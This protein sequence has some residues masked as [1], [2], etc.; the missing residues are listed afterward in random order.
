[1]MVIDADTGNVGIGDSSPAS[2]LTVGNNDLFQV[3]TSGQVIAGI[4]QGTAINDT[5]ISSSSNWNTAY[6]WGDHASEG[7]LTSF[8]ET[9]PIFV[10]SAA[11]GITGTNITNWNSAYGWGDHASAGYITASSTDTLTNKSNIS[12]SA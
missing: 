5:Y 10:A 6:G 2:M 11:N 12:F 4:W 3:N 8:S 1:L 9:D 7:Y